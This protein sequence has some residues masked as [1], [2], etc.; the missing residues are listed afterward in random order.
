MNILCRK[1]LC[2]ASATV[3]TLFGTSVA[4]SQALQLTSA[5][6]LAPGDVIT[7]AYPGSD[8]DLL[9][10]PFSL[11]VG[12]NTLTFTAQGGSTFLRV[13]AGEFVD[14]P[15][16][17]PLIQ[18]S[19]GNNPTGALR[20]DFAQGVREFGVQAQSAEF[21]TETFRFTAF[22]ASTSLGTFTVGPA[23]NTSNTGTSLFLGARVINAGRITQ[24]TIES[25]S[26][27]RN[28][29]FLL[30][31][32]TFSSS[33]PEPNA[34]AELAAIGISCLSFTVCRS[35]RRGRLQSKSV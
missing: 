15:L 18:T 24:V 1:C 6:D 13:D 11:Q 29:N 32:V 33:V 27:A 14:Y 22:D 28:N 12:G 3:L 35:R 10:S 2:L 26:S 34:L 30:G 19:D 7:P 4:H 20:I 25:L 5:S 9:A 8:G 31:A 23:D 17:T 16:D 21:D